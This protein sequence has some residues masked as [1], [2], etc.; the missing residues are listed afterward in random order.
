[1]IAPGHGYPPAT[2]SAEARLRH[3]ATQ[4]LRHYA[5]QI[6]LVEIDSHRITDTA[7]HRY[8]PRYGFT[9]YLT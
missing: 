9:F 7:T 4:Q 2:K 5:T 1:L 8:P 3:Y 6:P